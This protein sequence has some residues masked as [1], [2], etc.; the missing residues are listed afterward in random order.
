MSSYL[1]AGATAKIWVWIVNNFF[2]EQFERSFVRLL[3][4]LNIFT[5][6]TVK[7]LTSYSLNDLLIISCDVDKN[8][9]VTTE[10]KPTSS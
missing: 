8:I 7:I 2:S 9:L 10:F 4:K 1:Q 5:A 6:Q 3:T